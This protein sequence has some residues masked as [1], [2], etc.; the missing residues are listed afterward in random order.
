MFVSKISIK[1]I[2]FYKIN[3][4]DNYLN[5]LCFCLIILIYIKYNLMQT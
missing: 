3:N 5:N 4:E 1:I 2:L